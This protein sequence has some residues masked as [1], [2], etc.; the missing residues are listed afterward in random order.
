M[1]EKQFST[2]DSF[3]HSLDPRVKIIVAILFSGVVAISSIFS[4]L[5]S[6]LAVSIL[7][8]GLAG[9]S[10]RK[11][12][13]RFLLVNGLIFFLWLFLPCNPFGHDRATGN[14]AHLCPWPRHE[15]TLLSGQD[16]TNI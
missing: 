4:A 5:L 15:S 9:L 8:I 12:F 3:V 10:I 11:V 6:A 7:L 13:Y 14:N 2:G 1:I 16:N